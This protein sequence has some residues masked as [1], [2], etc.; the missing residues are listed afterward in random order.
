MWACKLL[1]AIDKTLVRQPRD[2][3]LPL[4]RPILQI[5]PLKLA[6]AF[7][8]ELV[9]SNV[10]YIGLTA[11]FQATTSQEQRQ[12][13]FELRQQ[14]AE[15]FILDLRGNGGGYLDQGV[16][17]CDQ[18]LQREILSQLPLELRLRHALRRQYRLIAGQRKLPV[19]L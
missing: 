19:F 4:L 16:R 18:L 13:M 11:G 8:Q 15:S 17:V 12:A 3:R 14:G 1:K 10:G 6:A 5:D 2:A 7:V 9:I